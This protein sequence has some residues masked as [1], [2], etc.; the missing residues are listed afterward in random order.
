MNYTD[1]RTKAIKKKPRLNRLSFLKM[2]VVLNTQLYYSP[3]AY[4]PPF[5]YYG[6]SR[7]FRIQVANKKKIDLDIIIFKRTRYL[8]PNMNISN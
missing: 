2:D 8:Y 6:W 7:M 5:F 3:R 4:L 1:R